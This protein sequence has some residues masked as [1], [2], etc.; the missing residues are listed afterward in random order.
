VSRDFY[1]NILGLF[2]EP[3][4]R[5]LGDFRGRGGQGAFSTIGGGFSGRFAAP[6]GTP[7]PSAPDS[8]PLPTTEG[9][10]PRGSPAFRGIKVI[11]VHGDLREM[12]QDVSRLP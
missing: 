9:I 4:G 8:P 5:G 11:V 7:V 10:P 12:I 1:H 6:P 2:R 3:S